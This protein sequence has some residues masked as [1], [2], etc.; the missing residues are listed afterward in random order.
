MADNSNKAWDRVSEERRKLVNQLI[1]KMKE[2]KTPSEA[3][4]NSMIIR[5]QN[6]TSKVYYQGGNRLKLGYIAAENEYKDPRWMTFKQASEEG[7]KIKKGEHGTVCEKWIFTEKVKEKDENGNVIER[8]QSLERPKVN[9]FTVFN[10]EQMEGVPPLELPERSK[11]EMLDIAK[12]FANSSECTVKEVASDSAY[13]SPSKDEIVM[14]LKEVFKSDEAFFKVQL[15]E[16]GHSTGHES[17]LSRDLSGDFGSEKYAKEELIAELT[18]VFV[19]GNLGVQLEGDHFNDHSN[20]LSHWIKALEDN[21]NVLYQAAVAAEKA[22]DRLQSNYENYLENVKENARGIEKEPVLIID[23]TE[24]LKSSVKC[25][26]FEKEDGD[27]HLRI[28]NL[29]DQSGKIENTQNFSM[30]NGGIFHDINLTKEGIENYKTSLSNIKNIYTTIRVENENL[31]KSNLYENSNGTYRLEDYSY[32]KDFT[33]GSYSIDEDRFKKLKEEFESTK[34]Y[35]GLT[36]GRFKMLNRTILYE[37]SDGKYSLRN[38]STQSDIM[39]DER[40][41]DKNDFEK[42]KKDFES[43]KTFEGTR[44]NIEDKSCKFV[45]YEHS[46]GTYQAGYFSQKYHTIENLYSLNKIE[47][48][49]LKKDVINSKLSEELQLKENVIL[50]LD[51]KDDYARIYNNVNQSYLIETSSHKYLLDEGEKF[52]GVT[53]T[54]QGIKEY[55]LSEK[56]KINSEV[57]TKDN[58]LNGKEYGDVSS[59]EDRKSN[60]EVSKTTPSKVKIKARTCSHSNSKEGGNEF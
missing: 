45:L 13:Y 16:M 9:Y 42:L 54:T 52:Q 40:Y 4:W 12:D 17:R 57:I 56:E 18:S 22:A 26:I 10:A 33:L 19:S 37:H 51:F 38:Y 23:L 43:V 20:Y 24:K 21:P 1:E 35:E 58:S 30:P 28:H 55:K 53:L 41:I 25:E 50:K 14:P 27:Y 6:P 46:D 3:L 7:Y 36:I 8:E 49:E 47:F 29:N 44:N 34:T 31:I 11:S 32:K 2:G 39:M 15:H 5:P 59:S 48:E 60:N